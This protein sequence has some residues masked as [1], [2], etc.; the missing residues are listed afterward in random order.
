[1]V[2]RSKLRQRFS[3][4]STYNSTNTRFREILNST[5]TCCN[6]SK[7]FCINL[8]PLFENLAKWWL[9]DHNQFVKLLARGGERRYFSFFSASLPHSISPVLRASLG[10]CRAG[11]L[12]TNFFLSK[13]HS[14]SNLAPLHEI[15]CIITAVSSNPSDHQ[16]AARAIQARS[17]VW[18]LPWQHLQEIS[19][20]EHS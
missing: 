3:S 10:H 20:R 9:P 13:F 17:N 19:F 6:D 14:V 5:W 8:D 1:M 16:K 4:F 2:R 7:T 11:L 18:P 15:S 12:P